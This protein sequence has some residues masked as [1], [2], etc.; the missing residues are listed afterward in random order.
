MVI[1]DGRRQR[2]KLNGVM[3]NAWEAFL[4]RY[5]MYSMPDSLIVCSDERVFTISFSFLETWKKML[6]LPD[7]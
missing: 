4:R 3:C 1:F 7:E 6:A 2:E 5:F